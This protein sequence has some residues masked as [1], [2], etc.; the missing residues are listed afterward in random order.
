MESYMSIA[1]AIVGIVITVG[2]AIVAML[3]D[4]SAKLSAVATKLDLLVDRLDANEVRQ[5]E[6]M[7]RVHERI[8]NLEARLAAKAR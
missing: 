2:I 7:R 3:L 8:D 1:V 4:A 5:N 6:D